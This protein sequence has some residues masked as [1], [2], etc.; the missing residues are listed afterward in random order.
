LADQLVTVNHTLVFTVDG[1]LTIAT[2]TGTELPNHVSRRAVDIQGKQAVRA[3][4]AQN[5]NTEIKLRMQFLR[6]NTTDDWVS[7]LPDYGAADM[8][9]RNQ[10]THWYSVP[11]HHPKDAMIVRAL[12]VGES[13][14]VRV[15]YVELDLR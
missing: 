9:Y 10:T 11:V 4:W 7:L 5:T 15:T 8:A 13:T 12:I 6:P 1:I 14:E 2:P 3:Q